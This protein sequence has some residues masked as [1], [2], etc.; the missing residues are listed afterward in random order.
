MT[1]LHAALRQHFDFPEFRPGQAE[2]LA[3]VLAGRD[4]LVVMP[5]GSGK[6]LIY[7][8]AALLLPGSTLVISPLVALMKDQADSLT[9]RG[10][11][12][13]FVNSSLD[14]AEQA[15]RLRGVAAGEHKI[16]LVAPERLRSRPFRLAISRTP[17][18][19]L[20]VD[21]AHCV[22]QWGHD[23][24]P[25]YLHVAEARR[26]LQ[27]PTT[28]ALTATATERV[29]TDII[30]L[31]GLPSA[32]RLVTG[33]N[34]S[35]LAFEV[36]PAPDTGTKLKRLGEFLREAAP[37]SGGIIY[38]GTRRDAESVA[39][40][41][42]DDLRIPSRFYHGQLESAARAEVQDSFL[43]GDLPV[44]VATNAFGLGID[45][46]DVRFVIH[47]ALPGSL[48]AYYQ[49]AGRAGRDGRPA[50]A[51]L[52][53]APRDTMV[54]QHFIDEDSPTAE[55][56]RG[57]HSALS[58][59]GAA[60]GAT[61]EALAQ[62]TGLTP[63]KL[64]VG[65]EQLEAAGALR[66]LPDEGFDVVRVEAQP[67]P[68]QALT[69]LAR[70]VAARRQH[71]RRQ[72][73]LMVGYADTEACRRQTLLRHFG[74]DGPAEADGDF[75]C[76]NCART[77]RPEATLPADGRTA[78]TRAERA[79]LIVLDTIRHLP[80]PLGKGKLAQ[81]LKG[82][83]SLAETSYAQ[84]RN[85]GKFAS[86]T[87]TS[88]EGLIGEMTAARYLRTTGGSRPVLALTAA[89][90]RALDERLALPVG[91]ALGA[92]A[93]PTPSRPAAPRTT[94][95][96]TV[97]ESGELLA[98]GLTVEQIA[99]Q[100]G[101][102]VGTIYSHLAQLIGEGKA[103]VQAVIPDEVA[104]QV[105]AAAEAVG[106]LERLAPLKARLPAELSYDIIRCVVEA[107]KREAREE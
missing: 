106:S 98:Q 16:V 54:H 42:N 77:A 35:N 95:G 21:E 32:T 101:L 13:T 3:H 31:L 67:L 37:G 43:A 14:G 103:A 60:D 80:W 63:V 12:A 83:A 102:T 99:A 6:S 11:P 30:R 38:T 55:E 18:S 48:E 56:L 84:V 47:Y 44:V 17:I 61:R 97:A 51:I 45:R 70:Q 89:G 52:L 15:R 66:R 25:D 90:E 33:F 36:W 104:A 64:R 34:R 71:K 50:R 5:T 85:F 69:A 59:P 82:H 41:V 22:S 26:E 88:I 96:A 9:R 94:P 76:D 75:C 20:V 62:A 2:A 78:E 74:D 65:L 29:Q 19:L 39:A 68:Q 87:L 23:F 91:K 72:L 27:V 8:L 93:H 79:A 49:E 58:A 7:Q 40:F 28:L 107:M 24:R 1:E 86:L 81:V 92:A 4:T 57:L 46:P 53:Y 105:R 10:L 73:D 100:R